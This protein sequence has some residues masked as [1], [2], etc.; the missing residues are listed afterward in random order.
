M[1][2]PAPHVLLPA[3]VAF[4]LAGCQRPEPEVAGDKFAEGRV[5][6]GKTEG[7]PVEK[8]EK[9]D[10]KR[11]RFAED[12]EPEA[13]AVAFDGERAMTYL[14]TLCDLGPRVSG[15]EG[16]RL[17]QDLLKKHF[18]KYGATVTFQKFD[19]KQ[20]SQ[21][22]AVPM[23]NM[24]VSWRP[25]AKR[26]LILCGHYDTRPIADQEP[27]M[28][29]WRKPFLSAN[30]GTSTVALFMELAHHLKDLPLKVG[31][32]FVIFDGEEFINDNKTDRFFLGSTFFG[33]NYKREKQEVKY[34]AAVLLDLFAG[35]HAVLRVEQNS[36]LLAGAL[37]EDV[38]AEAKRQG[39]KS[40]VWEPG[41]EV[42]DDH[43]ALNAANI[44][45][46]DLIDFD[47]PH[48][49]KLTDLPRE[50]SGEKM[51]EVARVLLGWA[52]RMK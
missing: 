21:K 12:R 33:T 44:P 23:A 15:T 22:A 29:D 13:A 2:R 5:K 6:D 41:P 11:D 34:L 51:A 43:L 20:P 35:K 7:P 8:D 14:K 10:A 40:F 32:D 17:Q 42:Q 18:E 39:A 26:R 3:L 46:I 28:G 37:C 16:M 30:D 48:W 19:G 24:I 1:V 50:C 4:A 45:A 47:Y 25:E 31:L 27:R 49:H 38:W 9:A 36:R 52:Q